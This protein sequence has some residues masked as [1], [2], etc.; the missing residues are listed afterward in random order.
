[1]THIRIISIAAMVA[2]AACAQ[3]DHAAGSPAAPVPLSPLQTSSGL[4]PALETF[5]PRVLSAAESAIID[6]LAAINPPG[7]EITRRLLSDKRVASITLPDERSQ[8]LLKRLDSLRRAAAVDAFAAH[9]AS[10]ISASLVLID[11]LDDTTATAVVVRRAGPHARDLILLPGATATGAHLSTALGTLFALRK[12]LGD[13]PSQNLRIT[14]HG[15]KQPT[16]WSADL[17]S[18]ADQMVR[19]LKTDTVTSIPGIGRGRVTSIPLMPSTT[20]AP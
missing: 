17:I 7:A 14:I 2:S 16:K 19:A 20:R 13:V 18:Q 5:K 11:Q 12:R 1:M 6:T 15:L 8:Q 10:D 4:P 3:N 9:A